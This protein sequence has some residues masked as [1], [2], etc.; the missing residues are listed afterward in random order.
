LRRLVID[1]NVL[2][3]GGVDP[4]GESPPSLLYRELGGSRFEAI[5]CPELL[6]EVDETLRKPYFLN[7]L[8]DAIVS[9]LV[10]GIVEAGT[11]LADPTDALALLRDPDDDYLV[12][13]ARGAG[14]EAIVSG[15]KDLLDH[16][17]LEPP[18]MNARDACK[19]LGLLD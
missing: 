5:V 16:P 13:L 10:T 19:L 18:A 6:A 2:A 14:A 4:Q 11:V 15:D 17:G 12:A 8:G 7:R 1:A 3:S 9:D